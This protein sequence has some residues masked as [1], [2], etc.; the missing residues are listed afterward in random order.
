[1]QYTKNGELASELRKVVQ[2]LRPWTRIN[3]KVVERSGQKL[4]DL[5]CRSNPWESSDCNR[6][7]C[8]TCKSSAKNSKNP[9]KSC[10]KRS[11][12]YE[13]WCNSC[14]MKK[15]DRKTDE[16]QSI[17]DVGGWLDEGGVNETSSAKIETSSAKKTTESELKRK[18][19]PDDEFGPYYRY[20]GESS[21]SAFERGGSCISSGDL[22]I[23]G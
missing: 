23:R 10:F 19:S 15:S 5:L 18:I 11:V 22:W 21:R 6:E 8:L 2:E 1:M 16:N 3:L 12:V 14:L 20:I 17:V 4:Q 7:N 9:Y 13:T